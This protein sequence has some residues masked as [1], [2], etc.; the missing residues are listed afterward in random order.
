MSRMRG[1]GRHK[2]KKS[3]VEKKQAAS[4]QSDKSPVKSEHDV[5]PVA[6]R[7]E[8]EAKQHGPQRPAAAAQGAASNQQSRQDNRESKEEKGKR[9]RKE[10]WRGRRKERTKLK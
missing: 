2:E 4:S 8:F 3:K 7:G 9:V 1:G 10:I 6:E 5:D